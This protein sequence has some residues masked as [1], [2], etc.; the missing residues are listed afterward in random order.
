ME[1]ETKEEASEVF[2]VDNALF[3]VYGAA[4]ESCHG[5][6][7]ATTKVVFLTVNDVYELE[8]DVNGVGGLAELATMLK[9]TRQRIPRDTH[10]IVTLNG[11]FLWRSELD[12]KDKGCV[13]DFTALHFSEGRLTS[14]CS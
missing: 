4:S 11:D 2:L 7:N 13:V 12:R 6:R 5:A 1:Q 9:A 10:V 8:P 14:C 3:P